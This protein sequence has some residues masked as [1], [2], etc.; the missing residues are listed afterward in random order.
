MNAAYNCKLGLKALDATLRTTYY[1]KAAQTRL[2][3]YINVAD[4]DAV[5]AIFFETRAIERR[6]QAVIFPAS[7]LLKVMNTLDI[8]YFVRCD[9]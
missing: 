6:K 4:F 1:I 9:A 2:I 3:L 5:V 8:I 7:S